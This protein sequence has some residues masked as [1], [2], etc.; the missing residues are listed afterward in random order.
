M[1]EKVPSEQSVKQVCIHPLY[2]KHLFGYK[3]AFLPL[4]VNYTCV[5]MSTVFSHLFQK[6]L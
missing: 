5:L 6:V 4:L 1:H 3:K 2:K